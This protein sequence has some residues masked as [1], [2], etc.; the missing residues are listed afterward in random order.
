[1]SKPQLL[2][3]GEAADLMNAFVDDPTTKNAT[4]IFSMII[5]HNIEPVVEWYTGLVKNGVD[6]VIALHQTMESVEKAFYLANSY[7]DVGT[8]VPDEEHY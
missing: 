2:G 1:M 3:E 4:A 8:V 7:V 6:P 5:P